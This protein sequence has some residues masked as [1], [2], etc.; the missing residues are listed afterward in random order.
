MPFQILLAASVKG[1]PAR[2]VD[3]TAMGSTDKTPLYQ[4]K[5]WTWALDLAEGRREFLT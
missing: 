3:Y 4:G 5:L 1:K 2:R